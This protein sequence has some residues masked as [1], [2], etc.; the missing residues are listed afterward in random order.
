MPIQSLVF[1]G[2]GSTLTSYGTLTAANG[3]SRLGAVFTFGNKTT[4]VESRIG[5]SFISSNQACANLDHDIPASMSFDDLVGATK[6]AWNDQ[7]LSKIIARTN[8][9][10]QLQL[11]YTML[12]GAFLI[13]SNKTDE[14]PLWN[15]VE[16]YY[17][18]TFT[19][20]DLNRC[21][22]AMWNV[23]QPTFYEEYV[24][25][26][27]D[28]FRY[29]GYMPDARSS[30]FNG[31]TQ[32][33]SNADNVL[34]DAYIKGVGRGPGGRVN[35]TD[36][37][38][39]MVKNAEVT[40]INNF[41]PQASDSSTKEGRG[42]LPDWKKYGW[43]TPT[44]SRAVSRAVE[45]AVNDFSL[46]QVASG[47]GNHADA[48]KY[49]NR[50]AQWRNHWNPKVASLGFSG[51]LVP[52]NADGSFLAQDPLSCGGCYWSDPYYEA[53]PWEYSFAAIHDVAT[54]VNF[55]GGADTFTR[56]LDTFFQ[57]GNNP[58]SATGTALFNYTLM[59]PSNEP[60]FTT[61]YLYHFVGRPDLSVQR[62]KFIANSY[63]STGKSGLPGNS[64]AGAMETWWLWNTIG[65][66]PITG[67]TTF[68]IHAPLFGMNVDLDA[69]KWLNITVSYTGGTGSSTTTGYQVQSLRVNGSDWKQ[70]WATY[71]DLFAH[72]ATMNFVLG[73]DYGG[74]F[75]GSALPPSPGQ[76]G[77]V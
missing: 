75:N 10:T 26:L 9:A 38:A 8:N 65:L 29:E 30:F 1:V 73:K 37:Y 62:S 14:N 76:A 22:T 11:M 27:I 45:Y 17:D 48:T 39:A 24:R 47:L 33:G 28:V 19:L 58:P 2:Q 21:S 15:S 43:I 46:Y 36:G 20:W 7:V 25:S 32:G 6:K 52:R 71:S 55:S 35:W 3:T 31:R 5:V 77:T 4:T 67:Q 59:N 63:Y 44:Y 66:Y 74:W 64:D 23:L 56:R 34:A 68:L 16:P 50:S 61:P 40:P 69:G 49:L 72:G 13:P 70:S 51:F 54:M 57:P 12:Y 42:A 60:D 53:L 41:D 18:D